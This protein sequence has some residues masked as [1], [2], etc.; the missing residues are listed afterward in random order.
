MRLRQSAA[1]NPLHPHWRTSWIARQPFDLATLLEPLDRED[2]RHTERSE[3]AGLSRNC[4]VFNE[5]RR[6]A[7][8]NVLAYKD[9]GNLDAW[10][11]RLFNEARALN[12]FALPLSLSE[13]RGIANSVAKW[14]WRWFSKERFSELSPYSVQRRWRGHVAASAT[15]LW[16]DEG[17][18]RA[19]YYRRQ[20][21]K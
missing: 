1:K 3:T 10:R 8:R 4:D 16:E 11:L 15:K 18:S 2:M 6:F 20:Q 13:L 19:T 9:R 17:I 21:E 5:L 12:V 14:T 7:Y